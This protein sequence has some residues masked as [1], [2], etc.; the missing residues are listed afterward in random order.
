M[1]YLILLL[2]LVSFS[3]ASLLNGIA[4]TVNE[5]PITLYDID[6]L[7]QA[8]QVPKEKAAFELIK[9]AITQQ[10]AKAK[11]ITMS[12]EQV[13]S[14]ISMIMEQNHMNKKQF[15]QQ[16]GLQG[17][18]YESFKKRI[19]AQLLQQRLMGVLTQDKITK[20]SESEKKAF[21]EL[22]KTEFAIPKTIEA[23]EYHSQDMQA[24]ES[25]KKSPLFAPANV[26]QRAVTLNAQQT[27]P[28]LYELLV[29][30]PNNSFTQIFP[31]GQGNYGMF[32]LSN[33]ADAKAPA[34]ETIKDKLTPMMQAEQRN[35]IVNN[36]FQDEIRKAK[37][38][39]LRIDP[40]P[41]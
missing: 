13:Q 8:S 7:A 17:M 1:K 6:T 27:N 38:K 34:F 37:I 35:S 12:D 30:T 20:P 31:L 21:Y 41:L 3:Q 33:K 16:L 19:K 40:L 39:Y 18:S 5:T 36:F 11:K 4:L 29:K 25:V 24:L 10:V 15:V 9:T 2:T 14:R 28:Q 32:Y 26:T 23:T 22:H